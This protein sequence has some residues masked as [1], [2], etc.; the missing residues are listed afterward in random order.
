M[1]GQVINSQQTAYGN[2]VHGHISVVFV[3]ELQVLDLAF[4]WLEGTCVLGCAD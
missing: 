2:F 1:N 4:S 3:I